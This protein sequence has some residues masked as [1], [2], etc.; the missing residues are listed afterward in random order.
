MPIGAA[1]QAS[2][3][4]RQSAGG[5]RM[6]YILSNTKVRVR[7]NGKD[8]LCVSEETVLEALLRQ[9]AEF[10]HACRQGVCF[11]CLSKAVVGRVPEEAQKGLKETLRHK[12]YF[13][14]CLCRPVED[15]EIS[16]PDE[17]QVYS[18]A[19]VIGVERCS[20]TVCRVFL[21]PAMPFSYHPGQYITLRR[22]DGLL[23]SYSLAS[24]PREDDY[25]EI[26]VRRHE[27]GRMSGWIFE[28]L[29]V[30]DRLDI[31]GP[32]GACFYT[33]GERVRPLLLIGTGTGLAPLIGIARDALHHG[34]LGPIYLYHGSRDPDGLYLKEELAR[35]QAAWPNFHYAPCVS[36]GSAIQ[37]HW[38]GRVDDIAFA[39]HPHLRAWRV[40]VCGAPPMV[41]AA[42]K[43]AYLAGAALT[44]IHG[45]AFEPR[46][47][48]GK[49][50]VA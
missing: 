35:M 16:G 49:S 22:G 8:Y 36:G 46:E 37:G 25:L 1:S 32:S 27:N 31:Q 24:V 19:V 5:S 50:R 17:R 12:G 23:R 33:P 30:G 11:A 28:E 34:H 39:E 45:D 47:P 43:R 18:R 9:G 3:S 15:L 38:R 7:F 4:E 40:F 13:F 41:H 29:A 48:T 26:H 44:D 21:S 42:R 6:N 14:P 2:E 20:R 10:P